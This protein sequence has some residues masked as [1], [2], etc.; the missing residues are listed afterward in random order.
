MY[1]VHGRVIV[2]NVHEFQH[3]NSHVDCNFDARLLS[4]TRKYRS[5]KKLRKA[6]LPTDSCINNF[7][8]SKLGHLHLAQSR[9]SKR[10][11]TAGV[12]PQ[13]GPETASALSLSS[14]LHEI[15]HCL[16]LLLCS[17]FAHCCHDPFIVRSTQTGPPFLGFTQIAH[18][19][20]CSRSTLTTVCF[21]SCSC[22]CFCSCFCFCLCFCFCFC[23]GVSE[24]H[25]RLTSLHL[26]VECEIHGP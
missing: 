22:S 1:S 2:D 24:I 9:V 8:A 15:S 20:R 5:T 4:K 6:R 14:S 11:P 21:S 3:S 25:H 16:L 12:Q 17:C 7:T 19:S 13:P 23:A 10:S 18:P 26:E